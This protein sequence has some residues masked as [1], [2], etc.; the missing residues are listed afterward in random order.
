MPDML[1]QLVAQAPDTRA[2]VIGGGIAGL[3]TARVLA[4]HFAHGGLI[5]RDHFPAGPQPRKGAPQA[6]HIHVVLAR[7]QRILFERFPDLEAHLQAAGAVPLDWVADALVY[8][9]AGYVPRFPSNLHGY[10]I[11]R[12][13]LEHAIR[14]CVYRLPNVH[15]LEGYD[16]VGLTAHPDGRTISG[17]QMQQR[18]SDRTPQ[19]LHAALTVDASGRSS[20]AGEWLGAYG[21]PA[22]HETIVNSFFGYGSA[23]FRPA[24]IAMPPAK[25]LLTRGAPPITRG[26]VML[27]VENNQW[28]ITLGGAARD[29]PPT[30]PAGFLDFAASL[31]MPQIAAI[32]RQGEFVGPIAGYRRM[33]NRMRHYERMP[34]WPDGFATLGD[35]VCAFNP[36][37]GQGITTAA[38]GAEVLDHVLRDARRHGTIAAATGRFQRMLAESYQT[39]W[40]MATSEDYRF[41]MTEGGRRNWQTRLAHWYFDQVAICAAAHPDIYQTFFEVTHLLQPPSALLH[42]AVAWRALTHRRHAR[43]SR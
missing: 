5:D 4:A 7:G 16:V 36:V 13:G 14:S 1:P 31:A 18:S 37:Y 33:E 11:T 21:Y 8:T 42:P 41:A 39:P 23:M 25:L 26:A 22:A 28:Q 38:I 20:R 12:D 30:D 2:I 17:V 3:A 40:L 15:L 32:L 9:I 19:T 24:A 29:H 43:H 34:R 6:R 35:A 27:A 10:S